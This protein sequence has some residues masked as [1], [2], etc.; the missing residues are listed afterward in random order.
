MNYAW[1]VM[2]GPWPLSPVI[3][4]RDLNI[5]LSFC[6]FCGTPRTV[7]ATNAP[8]LFH[9]PDDNHSLVMDLGS[10]DRERAIKL[11][12]NEVAAEDMRP[13]LRGPDPGVVRCKDILG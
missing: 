2:P 12:R 7:K 3:K 13:A 9:D 10:D 6:L 11:N 5:P 4:A 1:K 8:V